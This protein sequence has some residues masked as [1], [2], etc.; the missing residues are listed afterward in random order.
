M[1]GRF[2]TKKLRKVKRISFV[3]VGIPSSFSFFG[4]GISRTPMKLPREKGSWE[5]QKLRRK[6]TNPQLFEASKTAH[7]IT[8]FK[9]KKKKSY[10]VWGSQCHIH[11]DTELEGS[12]EESNQWWCPLL[13]EE[14]QLLRKWE[15]LPEQLPHFCHQWHNTRLEGLLVLC[16]REFLMF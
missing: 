13:P 10:R 4:S 8:V 3:V 9:K 15:Q 5:K 2:Q 1:A 7:G 6:Q 11:I 16:Q 12:T 14:L